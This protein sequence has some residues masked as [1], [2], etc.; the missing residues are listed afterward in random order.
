MVKVDLSV[1]IVSYNTRQLLGKC[2]RSVEKA[3]VPIT[4]QEV[5]IVD[6]GST[7]DS[8]KMVQRKFPWVKL[9]I[10]K[11]N[12]GFAGGCNLG[13]KRATGKYILF[14]NSD[15]VVRPD[16]FK[17]MVNFM[18]SDKT[19]G[20]ST[21]KTMLFTGGMDPDCHRG[22][23]TPWA[24]ICYFLGLEKLFPKSKIFGQYHKLYL[25]LDK[26]HEIDA[27]F[28]TFMFVRRQA[29]DKAG[30]WDE[31]YFFYGEDLDLSYRIKKAG[32]K[33]MFYP[34]PLV[35]HHKGASSGL[36][37]ESK[38]VTKASRQTRIKAAKASIRAME[39]FYKKFYQE[40]YPWWLTWFIIAGI[41][42]KG[43]F[44]VGRHYLKS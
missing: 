23:P 33:V 43:F 37:G 26:V 13:L 38:K 40:K 27:G 7:D 4:H 39:I 24:S 20:A 3:I 14:L 5:I 12:L 9:V 6:N 17:K 19:I 11:K 34:E 35:K 22:F 42:I 10:S 44:R 31:N 21:P 18:E 16:A 15:T 36:R 30:Y 41:K 32:Y 25:N 2:L 8:V 1:I 28:G 29:L